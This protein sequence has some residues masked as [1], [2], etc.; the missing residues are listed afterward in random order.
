MTCLMSALWRSALDVLHVALCRL[1]NLCR[2]CMYVHTYFVCM[3]TLLLL[4]FC[5]KDT[6]LWAFTPKVCG[7]AFKLVDSATSATPVADRCIKIEHTGMQSPKTNIGSRMTVLKSS[8]TFI[9]C[10]LSNKSVCL[11]SALL[12]L[13]R[14]NCMFLFY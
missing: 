5:S 12:E 13:P 1:C 7:H 14:V 8:V 4:C 2:L 3:D 11:I 6:L 9:G 10:H